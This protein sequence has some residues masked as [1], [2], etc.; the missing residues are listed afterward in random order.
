MWAK[1]ADFC[2]NS[3]RK[4]SHYFG[5]LLYIIL[6]SYNKLYNEISLVCKRPV[7]LVSRK[8]T[9][10]QK[11]QKKLPNYL[12]RASISRPNLPK[13]C[14]SAS[15]SVSGDRPPTNSLFDSNIFFS[16]FFF[17]VFTIQMTQWRREK[18]WTLTNNSS[19]FLLSPD[20]D[21]LDWADRTT[22]F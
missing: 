18:V 14:L 10:F 5:F 22:F 12:T 15:S 3:T 7:K 1:V 11:V 16:L 2:A 17:H 8:P 9:D 19:L 21:N 13:Y 6:R 20:L 4:K